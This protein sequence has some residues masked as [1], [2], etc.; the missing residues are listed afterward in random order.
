MTPK[1]YLSKTEISSYVSDILPLQVKAADSSQ[2]A[3]AAADICWTQ[4]GDCFTIRT[5]CDGD[6]HSFNDGVLLTLVQAGEGK[7]IATVDG[8]V[9][10]CTVKVRERRTASRDDVLK[11]YAADLHVH[12]THNHNEETFADRIGESTADLIDSVFVSKAVDSFVIADHAGL[13]KN[14]GFF[15]GFLDEESVPHEDMVVFPGAESELSILEYD[16]FGLFRK[17]SG[18][19]VT[20]NSNSMAEDPPTWEEF[21]DKF[22]TSPFV[23]AILNH[24]NAMGWRQGCIWSFQLQK[25]ARHPELKRIIKLVELGNGELDGDRILYHNTYSFA[26]DCGLKAAP[27]LNSDCHGE[28]HSPIGKT[29]LLAPEKSKEMFFDAIENRR[30]YACESGAV[31][32]TFSV[33]G[34]G[35]GETLPAAETYQFHVEASLLHPESDAAPV[36]CQVISDYGTEVLSMEFHKSADFTITSDSARYFYVVL[37]DLRN[38]RT[39]SAPVWT[40]RAFDDLS[41]L[42]QLVPLEN[43]DF[44]VLDELHGSDADALIDGD[45]TKAWDSMDTTAS[46]IIDTKKI[47]TVC[48]VSHYAPTFYHVDRNVPGFSKSVF[49]ANAVSEFVSQYRISVSCDGEHFTECKSGT[50][51]NYGGEEILSFPSVEARYVK[52]EALSTV[53]KET[54]SLILGKKHVKIGELSI[55]TK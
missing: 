27:C 21:F 44:S 2:P 9:L 54:G 23:T 12:S 40:G 14:T 50:I 35:M 42:D 32:L 47:H 24:P 49:L 16:R 38:R 52:F 48:G 28:Y 11:P 37:H 6:T 26:L 33:N 20:F 17:N 34:Y 22:K 55:F 10:T 30:V 45:P 3:L 25:N 53:G 29:F 39:W 7:V 36:W 15:Q 43:K 4:E 41:P 18:E 31:N 51:R 46:V 1:Y 13:T 8:Q 19:L 5:F